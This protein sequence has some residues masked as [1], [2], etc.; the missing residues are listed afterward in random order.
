MLD[1]Q[2][3]VVGRL[4][5]WRPVAGDVHLWIDESFGKAADDADEQAEDPGDSREKSGE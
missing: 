2:P 3:N 1:E 4:T 5:R